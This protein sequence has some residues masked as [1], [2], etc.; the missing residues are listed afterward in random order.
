MTVHYGISKSRPWYGCTRATATYGEPLCQSLS[1][2]PLDELAAGLSPHF[3]PS[4]IKMDI[5]GAEGAAL[6]GARRLIARHRPILAICLYHRQSDLWRIPLLI[7]SIC[8]GYR[9]YLRAHETDGWQTV[10]YAVPPERL[11][12]ACPGC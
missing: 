4:F 1:A 6:E 10:G 7:E 11:K 3:A 2:A 5:E 8:P 12:A 9:H